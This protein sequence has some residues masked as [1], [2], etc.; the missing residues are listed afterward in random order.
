MLHS[1]DLAGGGAALHR[2][3]A[4]IDLHWLEMQGFGPYRCP[5][6]CEQLTFSRTALLSLLHAFHPRILGAWM[7]ALE[8]PALM[9]HCYNV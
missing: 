7:R 9:A 8:A 3:E 1:Q 4:N 6:L 2:E 5:Q